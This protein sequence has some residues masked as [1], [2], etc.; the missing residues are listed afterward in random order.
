M[1]HVRDIRNMVEQGE[2]NA[3][4]EALDHL[5]DLGPKNTE[6]LKLKSTLYAVEGRFEEEAQVWEKIITEDQDDL[7]ALYFFQRRHLEERE[8]FYFTD[9]LPGGGRRFLAHPRALINAS[10]GG[11]FGCALFLLVSSYAQKYYILAS[12]FVSFSC[13]LIFVIVPWVFIIYF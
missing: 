10:L 8:S 11:L 5:L 13:F 4:H 9:I 1:K 2:H 6:A 3:A 7:D 12:P